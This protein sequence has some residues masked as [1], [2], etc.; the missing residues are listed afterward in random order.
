MGCCN[1]WNDWPADRRLSDNVY[2]F[3]INFIVVSDL[4]YLHYY[5]FKDYF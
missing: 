5:Y 4:A 1:M 3:G 2:V